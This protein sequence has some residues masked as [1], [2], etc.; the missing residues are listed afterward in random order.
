MNVYPGESFWRPGQRKHYV[1]TGEFRKPLKGEFYLSG[2]IPLAYQALADCCSEYHVMREATAQELKAEID[3]LRRKADQAW[4]LSG[5]ARKD[6]DHCDEVKQ[7][8]TAR[9]LEQQI[10]ALR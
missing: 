9:E 2:A 3:R 8:N 10:S 7:R 1:K 6:G 5:L 4:E